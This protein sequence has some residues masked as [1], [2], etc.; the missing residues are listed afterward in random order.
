MALR[1]AELDYLGGGKDEDDASALRLRFPRW[2]IWRGMSEQSKPTSWYATRACQPTLTAEQ[3]KRGLC[4]TL[5]ADTADELKALL[6]EQEQLIQ[7]MSTPAPAIPA[8]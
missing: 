4:C 1:E 6:E 2:L 3:A 5:D 7:Q 8:G